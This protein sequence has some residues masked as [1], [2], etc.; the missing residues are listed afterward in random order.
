MPSGLLVMKIFYF[1]FK[2]RKL[3]QQ[4]AFLVIEETK[5]LNKLQSLNLAM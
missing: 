4:K 1:N 3:S 2:I 5:I